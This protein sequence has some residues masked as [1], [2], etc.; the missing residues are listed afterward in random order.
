MRSSLL[1]VSML[2]VLLAGAVQ[3]PLAVA[4]SFDLSSA[5]I[6]D[7]Q[8]AMDKGALTSEKLTRLYLARIKAYDKQGPAINTV[9]TLNDKALAEARAL[10]KERKAKGPRSPLHGIPI[11]LKDNYDTYDLPTTAGSQLL[12]GSIPP[13]DAYVVKQLRDAGA[14]ILAKVNLS[15]FAGGGGSV[16]GAKDP[17]VLKLGAVPNGS[18]SMGL[19]TLN[20]HD[21]T[22]GPAGSSGGTGAAIA[23]DFAQFGLGTDT[24]G[25]VRGPSAANGIVGLKPTHGLLSRD[26]IVPLALTFDTGGP[27]ARSVY[28]IAIALGIMTGVDSADEATQK[29]AGKFDKDYT[30]YLRRGSLKGARIGVARDFMG[31]DAETDRVVEAALVTLREQG[32]VI[33]DPVKYPDY[34][35]QGRQGLSTLIMASE[36]KSQIA[37]YLKTTAPQYPKTLDDL[38]ERANDPK[39]GYRSPQKAYA[40]RYTASVALDLNDP[41]YL[42]AKNQGLALTRATIDALFTDYQLDAIVYPTSPRPATLIKPATP[43]APGGADSPTSIANQTGYPDLIVP[44]GMTKDGLPVTISFFGQAFSEPKLLGYGYDFEQATHARVLPKNTPALAADKFTY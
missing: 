32:A 43:P 40:L 37:D 7:V 11:V 21:L 1:R 35:L 34:L 28:D 9:I 13:D 44:A 22:R 17:E 42:A 29:S 39:T 24:G 20:P 30:K 25:S 5:T 2:C 16:G 27:M 15:E 26:G 14:I 36:F 3:A 38:V 18:S 31:R 41:I 23:A 33:V 12:A 4:T 8:A 6:A 19:Q 10:D